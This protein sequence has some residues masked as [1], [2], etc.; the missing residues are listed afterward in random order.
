MS[1]KDKLSKVI[2]G[3]GVVYFLLNCII[4]VVMCIFAVQAWMT[5]GMSPGYVVF[6]IPL[7]GM[8]SGYWIRI[9]KFGWWRS[10][11]IAGSFLILTAILLTAIFISPKMELLKQKKFESAQ[12]AKSLDTKINPPKV[13]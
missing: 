6:I 13:E 5:T 9:G 7:M 12:K 2:K 1:H 10:L 4:C 8:F 3:F 11:V